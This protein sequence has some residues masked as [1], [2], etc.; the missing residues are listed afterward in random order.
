MSKGFVVWF[1]GLSGSGKST[2]A[3]MLC[4]GAPRARRPRRGARRRRGAHAPLEGPRLLE[5]GSRHQ[6]PPHRLRRQAH[7]PRRR[8]RDDGGDQPLPRRSATSS[9][10]PIGHFSRS[11]ARARSRA[12]RARSPRASTRRRSPARSRASP[13]STIPTRRPRTPEVIVDTDKESKEESLAE[14]PRE[15]RGARVRRRGRTVTS[16]RARPTRP[17]RRRAHRAARRRARQ[18]LR[19]GAGQSQ[20]RRGGQDRSRVVALDERAASD[21]EMIAIGAFSPLQGLHEP[22]GLPPRGPRDAPRARL[23]LVDPDHPRSQ[24]GE[25]GLARDRPARRAPRRRQHRRGD[26]PQRQIHAPTRSS[27][28]ARSTR[29]PRTSTPASPT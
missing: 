4:G 9:A 28:R 1:T 24:P 13:A 5:G 27:R 15:A 20:A 19:D 8:L 16:R 12:H 10:P 18:P 26:G 7:R 29:P 2:L 22:E 23:A 21:I 25:G 17:P 3:A 14:D 11:T 6:R